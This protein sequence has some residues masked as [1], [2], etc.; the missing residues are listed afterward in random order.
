MKIT[1]AVESN[2]MLP[3]ILILF[4]LFLLS[5]SKVWASYLDRQKSKTMKNATRW[6]KIELELFSEV[7]AD[8]VN[9]FAMFLEKIALRKSGNNEIF[10]Y[11]KNTFEI[12]MDNEMF[13]QNNVD[14]VKAMNE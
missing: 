6:T 13:K 4:F 14:Q 9:N 11:S 12:E 1:K 2:V 5:D 8:A 7:L 3:L 10:Q